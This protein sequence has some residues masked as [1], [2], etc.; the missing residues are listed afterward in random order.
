[1]RKRRLA[2]VQ[3]GGA[4][5]ILP[6]RLHAGDTP[7]HGKQHPEAATVQ[8]KILVVDDERH[9][10]EG[11]RVSLLGAGH[12][13]E[14][15][16]DSWQAIKKIKEYPFE[17]AIIDLDLPPVHG[18]ALSGWDL[19]RIV[20]AFNPASAIVVVGAEETRDMKAYAEQ[21]EVSAF[22][23]KPISPA[24]LK[25]IVRVLRPDAG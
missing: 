5:R 11:L 2:P 25:A 7:Q 12:I 3:P 20:R 23:E 13:V 1:M 15:A 22:L 16:A 9:S 18:V 10:R 24:R 6:R 19:V 8:K 17:V 4:K 21:L 14:T